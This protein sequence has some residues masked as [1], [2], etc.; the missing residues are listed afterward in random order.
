[1]DY[2]A[3]LFVTKQLYYK[4]LIPFV[5]I[6]DADEIII[7]KKVDYLESYLTSPY[8]KQAVKGQISFF[9]DKDHFFSS[10]YCDLLEYKNCR[11][12]IGPC[13]ILGTA[14]E[15]YKFNNHNYLAGVHYSKESR[16][17]FMDFVELLYAL[18]NGKLPD[19]TN[20][21]WIV[22]QKLSKAHTD[23]ILEKNLSLRRY[24]GSSFDSYEFEKRYIEAIKRNEPEKLEWI[25]KKMNSTYDAEL[26]TSK[27]EALKYKYASLIAI[28]TRVSISNGVP[29]LQA[30][31]LSDSL[32][33]KLQR[34]HSTHECLAHIKES[35]FLFMEL[36]HSFPY[37]EKSHL[38]KQVLY[39]I[40]DHLYEQITLKNLS[41]YTQ[42]NATHLSTEFKKAVGHTIHKYIIQKKIAE[43]KHLLLFTS[44][45]YKEIA[46]QLS[47][48][49]QS[50]FIQSFKRIEDM[51]PLE[52]RN[53][54]FSSIF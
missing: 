15:S 42:K 47:F 10:F 33:Q 38:V 1:M 4:Y 41:D 48:S 22:R 43:A 5:V 24:D 34:I 52:F 18:L 31:S 25:F 39:Y 3:L 14:T 19:S 16:K 8:L 7:P 28:L 27:L 44:Q 49:S 35:S 51:T 40:D 36:I 23:V 53:K 11:V 9:E 50:H 46:L 20:Y 45:S 54:Y 12:L 32:I 13:G 6:N 26:S 2:E 21:K 37:S 30:Y 29:I 17:T